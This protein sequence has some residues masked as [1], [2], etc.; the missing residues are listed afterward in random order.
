MRAAHVK[1][2]S[3]TVVSPLPEGVYRLTSPFG[4]RVDPISGGYSEHA[5][6]DYAAPMGTPIHAVAEGVVTHAGPGIQ[7]RSN[8]LII[9]QH[10]INGETF[11]TWYIHMYDN[12]VLVKKGDTVKAGQVIGKVGSNGNST[13]PH[14]HLEVHDQNDKLMNPVQFL[15][16]QKAVDASQ[17]CG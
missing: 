8:N 7:G 16:D 1:D 9:I 13:G 5:G 3:N 15:K 10:K 17:V 12:G 4:Y 2:T 6:Q 11:Y 14:L